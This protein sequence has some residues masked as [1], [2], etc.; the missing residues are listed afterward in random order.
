MIILFFYLLLFIVLIYSFS[1][2]CYRFAS[3][4][5]RHVY[6]YARSCGRGFIPGGAVV[7]Y[8]VASILLGGRGGKDTGYSP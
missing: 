8:S 2:Q 7:V 6:R 5:L 1:V 4:F 3:L